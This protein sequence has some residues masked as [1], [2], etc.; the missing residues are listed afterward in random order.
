[1]IEV[2]VNNLNI[3]AHYIFLVQKEHY[4]KYNL[5]YLLNL[6]A[7]DCD[8]V[9]VDGITEG[10]ACTTLLASKL[11]DNENPLLIANSDQYINWNSNECMYAFDADTIDGGI[12]TFKSHHPKWSYV[13]V[14]ETGFVTKVAEKQVISDNATVGI[15][16]WKKGKEYVKYAQQMIDQNVRVNN[17]FYVCPVYNQAILDNKKIRIKEVKK[18]WGIGTPE[19]LK[20]FLENNK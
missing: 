13:E 15:Y 4:E 9:Q 16:Y 5:K 18:M 17:E 20:Y 6:I 10:A 14:G 1:M 2:V 19:D 8:I 11:I 12:L 3:E 7:P